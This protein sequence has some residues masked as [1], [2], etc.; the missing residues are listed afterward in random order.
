MLADAAFVPED[1]DLAGYA[2]SV[3]RPSISGTKRTRRSSVIPTTPFRESI[4]S[5]PRAKSW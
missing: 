4:A 5:A 1:S 2:V 3:G